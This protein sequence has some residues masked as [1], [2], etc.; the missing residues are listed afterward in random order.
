MEELDD[1][2]LLGYIDDVEGISFYA[3]K[4]DMGPSILNGIDSIHDTFVALSPLIKTEDHVKRMKLEVGSHLDELKAACQ[5][6]DERNVL[7]KMRIMRD[8]VN[9]LKAL[10]EKK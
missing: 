8:K 6:N 3:K 10:L 1:F 9:V 7:A 2:T 5:L 4:N